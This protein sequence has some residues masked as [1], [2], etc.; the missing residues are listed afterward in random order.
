MYMYREVGEGGRRGRGER[1]ERERERERER[2]EM[3]IAHIWKDYKLSY[4]HIKQYNS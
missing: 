4:Y 1:E 2:I 3:L